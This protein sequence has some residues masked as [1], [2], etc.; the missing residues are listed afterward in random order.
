VAGPA[1]TVRK[2]KD[3]SNANVEL[4]VMPIRA[5]DETVVSIAEASRDITDRQRLN[6]QRNILLR[7]SSHRLKNTL[8]T[9]QAI[10]AQTFQNTQTREAFQEAFEARLMALSNTHDLLTRNNWEGAWLRDL[11][12]QE[13]APY[14]LDKPL[15]LTI[16]GQDVQLQPKTALAFSLLFHELATN[17]VKHG[18]LSVPTGRVDVGWEVSDGSGQRR[19]RL[20]WVESGGPHVAKPSRRGLGS[21]LIERGLA[22]E[23]N[24][25]ARL[26]FDPSGVRCT[27]DVPLA[28]SEDAPS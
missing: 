14:R 26:D 17:A 24:G 18:A 28:Q 1:E 12:L 20:H 9:V 27:I 19:V 22:H 5:S 4:T 13:L 16:D 23:L 6:E 15:R 21:R 2:R 25:E 10:A 11:L 8:A 7:E 3:G